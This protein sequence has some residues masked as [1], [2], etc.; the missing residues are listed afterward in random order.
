MGAGI[1]VVSI[2]VVLAV[3]S[4]IQSL[5]LFS[6]VQSLGL[7]TVGT[8]AW[9]GSDWAAA[10]ILAA[11]GGFTWGVGVRR[12]RPSLG[13]GALAWVYGF[14]LV[15]IVLLFVRW[16]LGLQPWNAGSVLFIAGFISAFIALWGMGGF[17]AGYN[18]VE[19]AGLAV[20]HDVLDPTVIT[21]AFDPIQLGRHSIAFSRARIL[22][23]V[24]PLLGPLAIALGVVMLVIVAVMVVGSL[25]PGRI[26]TNDL[27]AAA[28]TP[29]GY[30]AGLLILGQPVTKLA[31]FILI[32][33]LIIGG[34][35]TIALGL[36]LL[37]N[38]LTTQ[39]VEAKG[40]APQPVYFTGD[41]AIKG[42]FGR[43]MNFFVR[44]GGFLLDWLNDIRHG[45]A[46]AVN[47]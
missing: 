24:R 36:A 32:A 43:T 31:F 15:G 45:A 37:I 17:S 29:A 23:I 33:V 6:L 26:Q 7:G 4:A 5:G 8:I 20:E 1:G 47:R 34:I 13:R 46:R 38:A 42:P 14:A 41:K 19:T 25:F 9:N 22:P 30:V 40:E 28:T 21:G 2:A 18:T 35:A 27:S 3:L 16:L 39:I 10:L 44:L 12:L 11:V